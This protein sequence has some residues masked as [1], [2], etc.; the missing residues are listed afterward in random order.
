VAGRIKSVEKFDDLIGNRTR[1]L[2]DFS[3]ATL[4]AVEYEVRILMNTL[5]F[6]VSTTL[7]L[8]LLPIT[9]AFLSGR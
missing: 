1:D 6:Q 3:T 8:F 5:F 7:L 9:F 2:S 4:L